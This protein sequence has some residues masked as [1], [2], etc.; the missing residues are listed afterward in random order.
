MAINN[1]L[2]GEICVCVPF[3]QSKSG[4]FL[5]YLAYICVL[6]CVNMVCVCLC[7]P[8]TCGEITILRFYV[9]GISPIFH[10]AIKIKHEHKCGSDWQHE[11]CENNWPKIEKVSDR[12]IL[13]DKSSFFF[14][15][16]S[17]VGACMYMYVL[18]FIIDIWIFV[19]FTCDRMNC[20][21]TA[22]QKTWQSN[23][24]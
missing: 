1:L 23:E 5:L 11:K 6:T 22:A 15:P 17:I 12:P 4:H 19:Y 3:S 14:S 24:E 20:D 2:P 7:A 13:P 8:N 9:C 16:C 18:V 10:N 21:R